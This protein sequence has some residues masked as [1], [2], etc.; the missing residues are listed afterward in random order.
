M[1]CAANGSVV[2]PAPDIN[3]R[4]LETF[5]GLAVNAV[6]ELILLFLTNL[7]ASRR[8]PLTSSPYSLAPSATWLVV[9]YL[10]ILSATDSF[11]LRSRVAVF[12][13]GLEATSIRGGED[14]DAGA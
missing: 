3:I 10:G 7:V 12:I 2:G 5:V 6:V 14:G 13:Q 1:G 4:G 8:F 11:Y 9:D